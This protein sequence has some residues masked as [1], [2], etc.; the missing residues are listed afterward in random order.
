MAGLPFQAHSLTSEQ[1]AHFVTPYAGKARERVFLEILRCGMHGQTDEELAS[2]LN[3]NPSTLRPRRVELQRAALIQPGPVTRKTQSG[4]EATVWIP[5][6]FQY[7]A[8][9]WKK[10]K[11]APTKAEKKKQ[12][13]LEIMQ[14]AKSFAEGAIRI[15]GFIALNNSLHRELAKL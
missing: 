1:A 4:A 5:T 7:N 9:W 10:K 11:K 6:G 14:N 3:M 2:R 15:T 12:L 8:N 13:E